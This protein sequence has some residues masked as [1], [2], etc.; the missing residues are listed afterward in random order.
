VGEQA[1]PVRS[2]LRSMTPK[3]SCAYRAAANDGRPTAEFGTSTIASTPSDVEPF[4]RN[5]RSHVGLVLVIGI[6]YLDLD[7]FWALPAKSSAAMRAA[8]TEPMPLVS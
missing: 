7:V 5:R 6:D 8:S 1:L 3:K 4:A 2:E